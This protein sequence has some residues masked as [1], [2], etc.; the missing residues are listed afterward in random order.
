MVS[1]WM[2]WNNEIL[3]I[4]QLHWQVMAP[5]SNSLLYPL[6]I[7]VTLFPTSFFWGTFNLLWFKK[8]NPKQT[9]VLDIVHSRNC[10]H[11]VVWRSLH[12]IWLYSPSSPPMYSNNIPWFV[13]LLFYYLR[14]LKLKKTPQ[15]HTHTFIRNTGVTWGLNDNQSQTACSVDMANL[16]KWGWTC[17]DEGGVQ[18]ML[19]KLRWMNFA[20]WM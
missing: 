20:V 18:A 15:T 4:V 3:F 9:E 5:Q 6:R 1:L 12:L 8:N 14:Y 2:R 7:N 16:L 10:S 17:V 11:K 13:H 19:T